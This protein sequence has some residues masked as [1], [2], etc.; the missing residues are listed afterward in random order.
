MKRV[1]RMLVMAGIVG[2]AAVCLIRPACV[3]PT[4]EEPG[5][6]VSIEPVSAWGHLFEE[7]QRLDDELERSTQ[8]LKAKEAIVG[9]VIA[10]RLNLLKAAA[11]Y[12]DLNSDQPRIR[13]QLEQEFPGVSY[14]LTLCR[15]IIARVRD[16]L[17]ER[18]PD[19]LD[20][21]VSSLETES[22][23][24]LRRFGNVCLPDAGP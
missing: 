7:R 11:R 1:S 20:G 4:G 8:R 6:H 12:R 10:G 16:E 13:H 18:A 17:M 24:H 14:E 19:Q 2:V 9:E 15:Q 22:A 3:L 23:E 21:V 5:S